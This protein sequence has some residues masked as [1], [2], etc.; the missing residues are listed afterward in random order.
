[1]TQSSVRFFVIMSGITTNPHPIPALCRGER[2]LLSRWI[3]QA[4]AGSL[5]TCTLLIIL[6]CGAYGFTIGLRNGWEMAGYVAVKIAVDEFSTSRSYLRTFDFAEWWHLFFDWF[7]CGHSLTPD[8]YEPHSD[9]R[10]IGLR[11][12]QV[13][14]GF[15]LVFGALRVSQAGREGGGGGLQTIVDARIV[16]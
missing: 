8:G 6:G 1:M 3:E 7:L 15:L 5:R 11:A 4:Q 9:L 13:A 14:G 16:P 10:H 12:L 2:D